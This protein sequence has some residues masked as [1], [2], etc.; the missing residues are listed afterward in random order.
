MLG[1]VRDLPVLTVGDGS[2]FLKQG[3]A[4]G[5]LLENNRVRFDISINALQRSGLT[6]S[7]KLLRVARSVEGG[8]Q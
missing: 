3:G 7:S 6:A 2:R 8:V 5:F 1:A 4:I